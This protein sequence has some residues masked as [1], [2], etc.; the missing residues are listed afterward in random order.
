MESGLG[1]ASHLWLN[2]YSLLRLLPRLLLIGLFTF[3]SSEVPPSPLLFSFAAPS[4]LPSSPSSP[5]S[6]SSSVSSDLPVVVPCTRGDQW[7]QSGSSSIRLLFPLL[8][9]SI[10][11]SSIAVSFTITTR[12]SSFSF[13]KLSICSV[14]AISWGS[15]PVFWLILR[16]LSFGES[17]L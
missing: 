9:F 8:T 6:S 13:N 2:G 1:G 5:P 15:I 16:M 4:T 7:R 17:V 3:S 14:A 12:P 10:W 11:A